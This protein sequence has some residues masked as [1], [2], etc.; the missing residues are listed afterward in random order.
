MNHLKDK[1]ALPKDL[2]SHV[3][4]LL[5]DP[6]T[7]GGLLYSVA[8]QEAG[9]IMEALQKACQSPAVIGHVD[10]PSAHPVMVIWHFFHKK[11]ADL[12]SQL[13]KPGADSLPPSTLLHLVH[14]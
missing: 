2:P 12:L 8:S 6:Q 7:S 13:Y 5:F 4:D 1:V 9:R 14:F 11:E 10:G 3:H